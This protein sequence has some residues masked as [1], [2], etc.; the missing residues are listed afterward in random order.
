MA[1]GERIPVSL[2]NRQSANLVWK[3]EFLSVWEYVRQFLEDDHGE[4]ICE[5]PVDG[6]GSFNRVDWYPYVIL[7]SHRIW[8][9][10]GKWIC[11]CIRERNCSSHTYSICIVDWH[12]C[13][14]YRIGECF[15]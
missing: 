6:I 13:I 12:E 7:Y 10:V 11:D 3:P 4:W 2:E 14:V 9:G 1:N 8:G 15:S 5:S